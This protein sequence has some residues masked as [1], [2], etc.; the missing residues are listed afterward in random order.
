MAQPAAG[1][2]LEVCLL[3]HR[4]D[5]ELAD[6]VETVAADD[7]QVPRALVLLGDQAGQTNACTNVNWSKPA[8]PP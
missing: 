6:D 8:G 5:Q 3:A 1:H 2:L 4:R 7:E